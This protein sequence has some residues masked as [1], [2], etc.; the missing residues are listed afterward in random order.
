MKKNRTTSL[1]PAQQKR[2]ILVFF[3][4]IVAALVY[5]TFLSD[6]SFLSIINKKSQSAEL[7]KE[8]IELKKDN[9]ELADEIDRAKNDLEFLEEVARKRNMLKKNEIIIDFSEKK[10]KEKKDIKK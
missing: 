2:V 5:L 9:A 7:E 4:F 1:S 10:Q 6:H 3:C 8:K